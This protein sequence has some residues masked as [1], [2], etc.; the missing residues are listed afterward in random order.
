MAEGKMSAPRPMADVSV[1]EIGL[2][3][4]GLHDLDGDVTLKTKELIEGDHVGQA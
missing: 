1:E 4:G 2:L 3:M